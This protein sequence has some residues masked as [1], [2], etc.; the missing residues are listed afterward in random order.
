MPI[1]SGDTGDFTCVTKNGDKGP[2]IENGRISGVGPRS[3]VTLPA[4]TQVILESLTSAPAELLGFPSSGQVSPGF[5]ADLVILRDDPAADISA[6]G[7]V[8]M[9]LRQGHVIYRGQ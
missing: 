7:D 9:T 3:E 4:S 5:D 1:V 2:W 6:F 8:A